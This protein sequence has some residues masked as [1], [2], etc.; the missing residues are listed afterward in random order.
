[1]ISAAAEPV[2]TMVPPSLSQGDDGAYSVTDTVKAVSV[3]NASKSYGVGKR[4]SSV[5]SSLDMSVQKGSM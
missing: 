3:R 4:R 5:L 1:M 2:V